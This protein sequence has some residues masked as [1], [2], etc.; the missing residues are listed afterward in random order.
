ME[1]ITIKEA[2]EQWGIST[3]AVTYHIVAGRIEGAVKKG[4][5][6]FIPVAAPKPEDLRKK[7]IRQTK[8]QSRRTLRCRAHQIKTHSR[9]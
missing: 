4:G 3:R 5:V 6:W 9:V 8:N 7:N 2:A 1:Y